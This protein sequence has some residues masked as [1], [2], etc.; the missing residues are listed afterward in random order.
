M[1]KQVIITDVNDLTNVSLPNHGTSYTVVSHKFIIDETLAQLAA[2]GFIVNKE[3]YC[4]NLNGEVALGVYY[5]QYGNDPDMDL[6]FTWANSYDKT[7]RFRCAIGAHTFISEARIIAGD[8]SNYGRVH[9]G[10]AQ[11]QVKDHIKLQIQGANSYFSALVQDKDKMK[12]ITVTDTEVAELMGILYFNDVI[13]SSQLINVKDE[14]KK[15]SF[16]YTT[17]ANSLWTIYNHIIVSLKKAHPKLWMEQ[18]KKLHTL[19]DSKYLSVVITPITGSQEEIEIDPNQINLL[20]QI[21]EI[22]SQ[23]LSPEIVEEVKKPVVLSL[24]DY[25]MD[26]ITDEQE[27]QIQEE[28]IEEIVHVSELST[29]H[30]SDQI[31]KAI[32][33]L[34]ENF[35]DLE[36]ENINEF[37]KPPIDLPV[38]SSEIVADAMEN[39][40]VKSEER[41]I[42]L[43][44]DVLDVSST[45]SLVEDILPLEEQVANELIAPITP[46]EKEVSADPVIDKRT[47]TTVEPEN[48]DWLTD[49]PTEDQNF[50]PNESVEDK[51]SKEH[52][53]DDLDFEF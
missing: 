15:S 12:G 21:E 40:P 26:E 37:P 48:L 30:K 27:D 22:E 47:E 53:I 38:Y 52:V 8:M 5:L 17:P 32:S 13:T 25:D 9:T 23:E 20:D 14:Y 24:D 6:M 46:E 42:E 11:Q 29:E 28:N 3:E 50:D 10:N 41:V 7:M 43:I 49:G 19:I 4:R 39:I 33:E 44:N 35:S 31:L 18:Q 45:E 36:E 2:G 1:P 16:T 51:T 34:D